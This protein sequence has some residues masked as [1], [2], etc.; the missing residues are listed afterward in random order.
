MPEGPEIKYITEIC[1]KY[2]IG[3]K[4][5]D[6]VCNTKAKIKLPSKDIIN[7]VNCI[8]KLMWL[9]T[10]NYFFHI[11]FGLT[12]WLLFNNSKYPKYILKFAN[13]FDV[14][15]D[16]MRRFSKLKIYT[17][18]KK[19]L[20]RLNKLGIDILKKEFTLD[21]F[22]EILLNRSKIISGI[23]LEQKYFAGLGNYIRNEALYRA[24]INP[25]R[26]SNDLS[27]DEIKKLYEKIRLVS[28]SSLYEQLKNDKL[29]ISKEIKNVS[30]NKL[31]IPYNFIVYEKD[32]DPYGN[33]ITHKMISGR[34]TYYVKSVQK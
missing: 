10:K 29:S 22:R 23:L 27:N 4:L 17:D 31:I 25:E 26:K 2:L 13:D 9:E 20:K 33:K 8:G 24:K 1:K 7:N 15:I 34:R 14:Y 3:K 6:I 12:G 21:Y 28:F 16:D 11:H 19:H 5:I 30:P 32:Y 18:E